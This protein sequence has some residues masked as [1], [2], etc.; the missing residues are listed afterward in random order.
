MPEERILRALEQQGVGIGTFGLSFNGEDLR[1]HILREIPELSWIA[2]NVSGC[3]ANVQVRER[4]LPP[5]LIQ[6]RVPANVVA[7][8]AGLVL[9]VRALDGV[10]SVLPGTS[11]TKGQLLISG[12]EDL[13]TLGARVLA[14]LGSVQA[15]T[16]Y[17]LSAEIPLTAQEKQYTDALFESVRYVPQ[18]EDT[19][20]FK[21]TIMMIKNQ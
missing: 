13:E 6:D 15:R 3:R 21:D 2:V 20:L 18:S 17:E 1:N 8:R 12:V 5:E 16:W 19:E 14:S 4:V 9:K 11:V 10:A 7:R